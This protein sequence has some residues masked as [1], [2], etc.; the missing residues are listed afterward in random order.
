M[1]KMLGPQYRKIFNDALNL[2]LIRS[3]EPLIR[4]VIAQLLTPIAA[5]GRGEL[6]TRTCSCTASSS[7]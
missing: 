2:R 7:D 3:K 1:G 4:S 5:R 6:I